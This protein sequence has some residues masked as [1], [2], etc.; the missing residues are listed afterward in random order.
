MS[1][2]SAAAA[3]IRQEVQALAEPRVRMEYRA[4][5]AVPASMVDQW[6][7]DGWEVIDDDDDDDG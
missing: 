5:A 4:Q 2:E 7:A 3:A 1:W 6:Q